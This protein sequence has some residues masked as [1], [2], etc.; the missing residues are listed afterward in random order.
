MID[1]ITGAVIGSSLLSAFGASSAA[2]KQEKAANAALA[3]QQQMYNDQQKR[4]QPYYAAG[5]KSLADLQALMANPSSIENDPMYQWRM[6]QGQQALERNM[7]ARGGMLGG[8]ALKELSRYGQGFASQEFQNQFNRLATLAGYGTQAGG[9][10]NQASANFGAQGA[11]LMTGIGNSQAGATL[12]SI[13][14]INNGLNTYLNYNL[15]QQML[16]SLK[17]GG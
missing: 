8:A 9:M 5:A 15:N 6:G 12:G 11:D 14:A 17:P 2:K 16:N 4:M 3:F 13:G 7:A 10:M 1:P